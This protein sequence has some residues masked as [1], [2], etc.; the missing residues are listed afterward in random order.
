MALAK[1]K[2]KKNEE[3]FFE[4]LSITT[5]SNYTVI[6]CENTGP[7]LKEWTGILPNVILEN[8]ELQVGKKF[9]M[10][11][12]T[13]SVPDVSRK[14]YRTTFSSKELSQLT[15]EREWGAQEE[16]SVIKKGSKVYK[17]KEGSEEYDDASNSLYLVLSE[18][19]A[20]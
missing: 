16:K 17:V 10:K 15:V 19:T 8:K 7:V 13:Q 9:D 11:T 14:R 4:G 3:M 6:S 5:D 1:W 20:N 2:E 12:N 18:Q